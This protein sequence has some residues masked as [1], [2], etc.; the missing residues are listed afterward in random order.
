VQVG[1][2]IFD[3]NPSSAELFVDGNPV[4][5][6]SQFTPT[7]QQPLGLAPGRHH[8]EIRA[9][10]YHTMRFDA[11]ITVGRVIPYQGTLNFVVPS[12]IARS[13]NPAASG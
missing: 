4:G 2:L 12:L 13:R 7:T 1:G 8:V 3:V 11:H 9:A 5:S 10:G 6:V